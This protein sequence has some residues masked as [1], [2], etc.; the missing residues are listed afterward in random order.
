MPAIKSSIEEFVIWCHATING[1][2]YAMAETKH[3]TES[4]LQTREIKNP[5]SSAFPKEQVK[6]Y[7]NQTQISIIRRGRLFAK[8]LL[9]RTT[10]RDK[11]SEGESKTQVQCGNSIVNNH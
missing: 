1:D 6:I 9:S 11:K 2:E 3:L 10:T 4:F 5:F 7:T 8:N